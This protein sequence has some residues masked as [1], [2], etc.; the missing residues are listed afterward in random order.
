[1]SVCRVSDGK[2]VSSH[3]PACFFVTPRR[4]KKKKTFGR[5]SSP[6]PQTWREQMVSIGPLQRA[7]LS[8]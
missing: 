1:M 4:K 7:F 2:A 5:R 6:A 3:P 8:D